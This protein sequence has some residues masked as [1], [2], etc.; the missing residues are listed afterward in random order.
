MKP[1]PSTKIPRHLGG[2][3]NRK[4]NAI[5][6]RSFAGQF[7][8]L[9]R[10]RKQGVQLPMRIEV[11]PPPKTSSSQDSCFQA[12]WDPR[13]Q[14][15]RNMDSFDLLARSQILGSRQIEMYNVSASSC[16]TTLKE[17]YL[18]SNRRTPGALVRN[19]GR[20]MR[21]R[22]FSLFEQG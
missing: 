2:A 4:T 14:G 1:V 10:G 18:P 8:R 15:P 11:A 9:L 22:R 3:D 17:E 20:T 12:D 16:T 7:R 21:A 13:S 19:L 5:S 6:R